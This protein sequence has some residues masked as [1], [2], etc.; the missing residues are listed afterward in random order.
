MRAHTQVHTA[1]CIHT[2]STCALKRT[3]SAWTETS[4]PVCCPPG[5][6]HLSFPQKGCWWAPVCYLGAKEIARALLVP[7]AQGPGHTHHI[8][9]PCPMEKVLCPGGTPS[10]GPQFPS[11]RRCACVYTHTHTYTHVRT[12]V[13]TGCASGFR[14]D[15]GGLV[16]KSCLTVATPLAV[17]LQAPLSMGFSRQEYWSGLPFPSPGNLPNPGI[18]PRSPAVQADSLPTELPG[19]PLDLGSGLTI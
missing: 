16:T 15:G 13:Q 4:A 17:P 9:S 10:S 19:K 1:V 8:H 5:P 3:P 12:P 18:K 6:K 11:C 2:I 14:L 7:R